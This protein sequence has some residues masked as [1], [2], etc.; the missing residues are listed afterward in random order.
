MIHIYFILFY[1][2]GYK[3]FD[4]CATRIL[5]G[6]PANVLKVMIEV[7]LMTTCSL[8]VYTVIIECILLCLFHIKSYT[9]YIL[10]MHSDI[11][12]M[13]TSPVRC[14]KCV[15]AVSIPTYINFGLC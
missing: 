6:S 1:V 7:S 4:S 9:Q 2:V 10:D 3:Y 5:K 13:C 12:K 11:L 8:S 14:D 15:G